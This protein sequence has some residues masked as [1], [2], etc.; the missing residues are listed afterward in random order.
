MLEPSSGPCKPPGIPPE[1][2]NLCGENLQFRQRHQVHHSLHHRDRAKEREKNTNIAM[3][4]KLLF[5]FIILFQTILRGT[6]PFDGFVDSFQPGLVAA[7]NSSAGFVLDHCWWGS[8]RRLFKAILAV[9]RAIAA[10]SSAEKKSSY[11]VNFQSVNTFIF[12]RLKFNHAIN[13]FGEMTLVVSD[14]DVVGVSS[15]SHHVWSRDVHNTIK[16][17]TNIN[18]T[19]TWAPRGAGGMSNSSNL[20]RKLLSLVRAHLHIPV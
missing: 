18:I 5:F 16:L 10:S 9:I 14:K 13:L 2:L 17:A 8:L 3:A 6:E 7:L 15:P 19:S 1:N 20:L 4:S 11:H 12:Q